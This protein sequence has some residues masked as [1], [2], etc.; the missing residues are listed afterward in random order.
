VHDKRRKCHHGSTIKGRATLQQDVVNRE[1]FL[2]TGEASESNARYGGATTGILFV[3][4][5]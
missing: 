5:E 4:G 1:M 3:R 2:I